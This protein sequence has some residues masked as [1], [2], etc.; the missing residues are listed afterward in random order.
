MSYLRDAKHI[1]HP[2]IT[3]KDLAALSQTVLSL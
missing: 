2:E 1:L 3:E